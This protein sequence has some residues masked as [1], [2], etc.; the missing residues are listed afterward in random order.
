MDKGKNRNDLLAAGRKKLQ[1]YRKKKD[2]KGSNSNSG[3]SKGKASSKST[4]L[5]AVSTA[6]ADQL[7]AN[8][9]SDNGVGEDLRGDAED[10]SVNNATDQQ[11]AET[12][13][14]LM[15]SD[16][17][18]ASGSTSLHGNLE[19]KRNQEDADPSNYKEISYSGSE[20]PIHEEERENWSTCAEEREEADGERIGEVC[21]RNETSA[22]EILQHDLNPDNVISTIYTE[23]PTS[24]E[25]ESGV[26]INR[27]TEISAKGTQVEESLESIKRELY[28]MGLSRD[29]LQSKLDEETTSSTELSKELMQCK[30]E[31]LDVMRA[32]EEVGLQLARARHDIDLCNSKCEK[33]ETELGISKEK[34]ENAFSQL[35]ALESENASIKQE[36]EELE[37]VK[38][39]LS[40]ENNKLSTELLAQK[41]RLVQL[42]SCIKETGTCV[43]RLVEENIYLSS[44][45]NLHRSIL[46]EADENSTTLPKLPS[47]CP[48]YS[49][50]NVHIEESKNI[51]GNLRSSI[52]S[53]RGRSISFNKRGGIT[54]LI[55][56]YESQVTQV[57]TV[58]SDEV[59]SAEASEG[60]YE[61][62]VQFVGSLERALNQMKL[63][64]MNTNDQYEGG[65]AVENSKEDCTAIKEKIDGL[66]VIFNTYQ[67]KIDN[68]HEQFSS[69]QKEAD[70]EA[71]R[72][73]GQLEEL[74]NETNGRF[75]KLGEERDSMVSAVSEAILRFNSCMGLSVPDKLSPDS[76][77]VGPILFTLVDSAVQSI[78]RLRME[79]STLQNRN[80]I[81]FGLIR[82]MHDKLQNTI[83]YSEHV[84]G[85]IMSSEGDL[86][87]ISNSYEALIE[88]VQVLVEEGAG[89][90]SMKKE[91]ESALT[92]KSKEAEEFSVK[93]SSLSENLND[94]CLIKKDLESILMGK[95]LVLEE[96][97]VRCLALANKMRECEEVADVASG[98][99]ENELLNSILPQLESSVALS[100]E[101]HDQELAEIDLS[102][103]YLYEANAMPD[104]SPEKWALPLHI[105]LSS[106]LLPKLSEM[107]ER[108][109]LLSGSNIELQTEIQVLRD[110]LKEME[111]SVRQSQLELNQKTTELVQSEQRLSSVKEKLGI[112]VSKGKGLI[113]QR[114]SLKQSLQEKSSELERCMQQL[115]EAEDKLKSYGEADRIEALESELSYIRNSYNVLRDSFLI[116]DSVIQRIE[117]VLEEL[118]FPEE[119]HA[120][121]IA[122]KVEV[123]SR[124]AVPSWNSS[125]MQVESPVQV[126]LPQ[127]SSDAGNDEINRYATLERKFC[128]VAE[129]NNILEQSLLER[130]GIIQ[131]WEEVLAHISI[132]PPQIRDLDAEE[133]I[134]WLVKTLFDT[135]GDRD[136]LQLKIES[137]EES[138]EMLI[139][140]LEGSRKRISELNAELAAVRSE[141]EFFSDSLDKLR[142]D[143]E[144]ERENMRKQL[145]GLREKIS[146]KIEAENEIL[147][148]VDIVQKALP[149]DDSYEELSGVS[150]F[151]ILEKLVNK[152][153]E[154]RN[155]GSFKSRDPVDL[156]ALEK[157]KSLIEEVQRSKVEITHMSEKYQEVVGEHELAVKQRDSLLQQLEGLEE[158]SRRISMLEEERAHS[159]KKH[160]ELGVE[161]ELVVE[162]RNT[163]QLELQRLQERQLQE[164]EALNG[165]I[166]LLESELELTVGQRNTLQEQLN[167]LHQLQDKHVQELGM[168]NARINLLEEERTHEPEKH[169]K[170]VSELESTVKE[171]NVLQEQLNQVREKLNVAV[172]KGKGLVQ[173]R[174]GLKQQI[175]N[176][177]AEKSSLLSRLEENIQLL[178]KFSTVLHTVDA[179][180]VDPIQKVE[181]I[182]KSNTDLKMAVASAEAEANK[183]RR[184]TE[185]LLA[186]LNESQERNDM[187][188]EELERMRRKQME[189]MR[190]MS[191]AVGK[192]RDISFEILRNIVGKLHKDV[193][194]MSYMEE[195][196]SLMASGVDGPGSS[197]DYTSSL[198]LL[199]KDISTRQR[200]HSTHYPFGLKLDEWDENIIA[201]ICACAQELHD[202][203]ISIDNAASL[204]DQKGSHLL[205][206]MSFAQ[207]ELESLQ[208]DVNKLRTEMREKEEEKSL[209]SHNLSLLYESCSRIIDEA[210][211][212]LT[213]R[214]WRD[215]QATPLMNE[216]HIQSLVE[217]LVGAIRSEVR[218]KELKSTIMEL[219]RELQEKDLQVSRISSELSSQIRDSEEKVR[220]LEKQ[221]EAMGSE[222]A[223][224]QLHVNQLQ[225]VEFS[226]NQLRERVS[227]YTDILAKKEQEIESLMQALDEQEKEMEEMEIKNKQLQNLVQEREI[228]LKSLE[229]SNSKVSK[230]LSIATAKFD[231]LHHLSENL[232]VE[233]ENLQLQLEGRD[234]E[235]SFLRQEVTRVTNELLSS[236]ETYKRYAAHLQD[237]AKWVQT[238]V[239]RFGLSYNESDELDYSKIKEYTEALDRKLG[240]VV[241]ELDELH[242]GMKSRDG[243]LQIER[244]KVADLVRKCEGLESSLRERSVGASTSGVLEIE[245][246]REMVMNVRSGRKGNNANTNNNG[247]SDQVAISIDQDVHDHP[248]DEDDDK[249]HGFKP[250]T[251]SRFVPRFTRRLADRVDGMWVSGD[252]LL[253]RQPTLRIGVL[254]Y[255]IILHAMLASSI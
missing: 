241:A 30:S 110:S 99:R 156:E 145:S 177:E 251:M 61:I 201:Y 148:L 167:D 185:L 82:Q 191:L 26:C 175:E 187:L 88:H 255:W 54:N 229:G 154:E 96:L 16:Q 92:L 139:V 134:N 46:I 232:I 85:E 207:K 159:S 93:C 186:E 37:G 163:L 164:A 53:M 45:F 173:Q 168:L 115:M 66:S 75:Q 23:H 149:N 71:A 103:K 242:V 155:V 233:V 215:L 87:L 64:L 13:A 95:N 142:F 102:K 182:L 4:D 228:S 174:D 143:Y 105:L 25:E 43:E 34:L 76:T 48:N 60:P 21:S 70:D 178:N 197:S 237:F 153:L 24:L 204:V 196:M 227:Y 198:S 77:D 11:V 107:R 136:A 202:L 127:E 90:L 250:L 124:M 213:N 47:T 2:N 243:L 194:I 98:D 79:N 86:E 224:L 253:M 165:R 132:I 170:L 176:L 169:Q 55:K 18:E 100:L 62:S 101:K 29:L 254:I 108:M 80:E 248:L 56:A 84:A 222:K 28:L 7:D 119:F 179:D 81:S 97:H 181:A 8:L 151:H 94:F 252:R 36:R 162:Q 200:N 126:E 217:R 161:M 223:A 123:L 14:V 42:E 72:L 146:E 12:E 31:L 246:A 203:K 52:E 117:E 44:S 212:D 128:E 192:L 1:Q 118:D 150:S 33:L 137:L 114:D 39:I 104:I 172:R 113:V 50:L 152:L 211:A 208:S 35:E 180:S 158:L 20:N 130:N 184:A 188:L 38:D 74:Q 205:R 210:E 218:T 230:K 157:N 122:E 131:K 249:A 183:S 112:A 59:V 106:H 234:S 3:N 10:V 91:L 15:S 111:V 171:R 239:L 40:R 147:R 135:Q 138:S 19:D 121:D 193:G 63:D 206:S 236:D 32:K 27:E 231:E 235:I 226:S 166:S 225:D 240:S 51:L 160:Q 89:L 49:T 129:H 109:D 216:D 57:G 141:K 133:R 69:V 244:G 140:D 144:V 245:H 6:N 120:R 209:L 9:A 17:V 214:P 190:E 221:V 58:A 247:G 68:L 73:L 238:L 67:D 22:S 83:N 65:N 189:G 125:S 116:K 220:E 195:F 199:D 5:E 41:E 219:Q 78:E